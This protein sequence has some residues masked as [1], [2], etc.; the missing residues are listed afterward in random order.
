MFGLVGL[1]ALI[2]TGLS[3]NVRNTITDLG[4]KTIKQGKLDSETID[5]S[6]LPKGI[7]MLSL[8]TCEDIITEKIVIE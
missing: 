4:G 5:I 2:L 1:A 3:L 7:N 6:G 8:H